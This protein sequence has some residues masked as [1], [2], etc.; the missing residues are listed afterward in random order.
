MG[1]D[2]TPGRKSRAFPPPHKS[3]DPGSRAPSCSLIMSTGNKL[4]TPVVESRRDQL[5]IYPK[6]APIPSNPRH[7]RLCWLI[8]KS[9]LAYDV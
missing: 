7:D 1:K 4:T 5:D 8:Q 6:P 2:S 9:G 3:D